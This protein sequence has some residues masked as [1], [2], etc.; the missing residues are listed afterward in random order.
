MFTLMTN[1]STTDL[2]EALDGVDFPAGKQELIEQ[3]RSNSASEDILS[4]LERL[5]EDKQYNAV[6]EV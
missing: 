2:Q 6:T 1:I 4:A 3:A 5:E